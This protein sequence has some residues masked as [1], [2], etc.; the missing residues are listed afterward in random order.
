[1]SYRS[2]H[3]HLKES[4]ALPLE[5]VMTHAHRGYLPA[6]GLDL[7]LPFYDP[8]L[9][10]FGADRLRQR[11]FDLASVQAHHRVLDIGCGT[12]TFAVALKRSLPPLWLVGLDPDPKAIAR[13]RRK[14][15]RAGV[16][17]R[18]DLG[19]AELLPYPDASFDRVFSC[20]MFHHLP[21]EAKLRTLQE[22]RRVLKC[23]GSLHLLD[24]ERAPS[25][26][27][28]LFARWSHSSDQMRDNSREQIL[29]WLLEA[30]LVPIL[31]SSD[32]SIFGKVLHLAARSDG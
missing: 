24:L 13:S 8:L 14:A 4:A 11:L 2:H 10:L 26:R 22:V 23:G 28:G 16:S 25:A 6:A 12:G 19:F 32:Q 30:G 29:K 18:F 20:L 17:I 15:Q 3:F 1:M 27:S 7:L 21:R 5:H 9:R 31:Q